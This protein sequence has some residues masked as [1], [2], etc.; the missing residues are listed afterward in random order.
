MTAR[1]STIRA[2][3]AAKETQDTRIAQK[4]L[5]AHRE[6]FRTRFPG[7]VEHCLRLITERLQHCLNKPE[8]CDLSDPIT[9]PASP[10]DILSLARALESVWVVYREQPT[11]EE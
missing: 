9:W 1:D 6:A 2:A 8:G 3:I 7:A 4:V 5:G 11:G 10:D